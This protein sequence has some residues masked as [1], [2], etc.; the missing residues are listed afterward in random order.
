MNP[1]MVGALG[2]GV[3]FILMFLGLH[4]GVAMFLTGFIGLGVLT[5]MYTGVSILGISPFATTSSYMFT[6][7]P[8]FILMGLIAYE[9]GL[10]TELFDG[11]YKMVGSL[12]GGLAIAVIWWCAAF[13]AITGESLAA[14]IIMSKIAFPEMKRCKYDV[15]LAAG[16]ITSGGTLGI[17]IPPSAGFVLYGIITQTNIGALLISGIMPGLLL[18]V[19]FTVSIYSRV[20]LNPA[21][22]IAGPR[23]SWRERLDGARYAWPVVVMFVIVIGGIYIGFFT[24][25]EAGAVG[26]FL[27][28]VLV[29]IKRKASIKNLVPAFRDTVQAT[30]MVFT[31]LIGAMVYNYFLATSQLPMQLADIVSAAGLSKYVVFLGVAII[32]LILGCLM[33]VPAMILLTMP[34]LFPIMMKV[35]FDP[36]WFGV[37]SVLLSEA[38]AITPPVGMNAYVVAGILKGEVPLWDVFRGIWPFFYM[39][40]VCLALITIFPQICLFL[41]NLMK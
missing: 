10:V 32:L 18:T 38:G 40:L 17:L 9:G 41:P 13:A 22:A 37:V 1:M 20:K 21:L 33:D 16:T 31:I 23:Y 36:I 27:A 39:V 19:L 6:V 25:I 3:L 12:P 26:V 24:P 15:R 8:L 34:I 35:G 28:F 2:T 14:S 30:G 11:L 4:V 7:L 5:T 29:L